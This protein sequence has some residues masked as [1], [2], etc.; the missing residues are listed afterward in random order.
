MSTHRPEARRD[1]NGDNSAS[2]NLRR[3]AEVLRVRLE[4]GRDLGQGIEHSARSSA[5]ATGHGAVRGVG[6]GCSVVPLWYVNE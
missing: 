1:G 5:K 4:W 6:P 3:A 2:E